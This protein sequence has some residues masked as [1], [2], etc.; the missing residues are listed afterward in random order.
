MQ[1][2]YK[3]HLRD[4]NKMDEFLSRYAIPGL[5][6]NVN[7]DYFKLDLFKDY[8]SAV[9]D[10]IPWVLEDSEALIAGAATYLG[11]ILYSRTHNKCKDLELLDFVLLY[12]N[13][14]Y[15]LDSNKLDESEKRE[16]VKEC[17]K[18]IHNLKHNEQVEIKNYKIQKGYQN[19]CNL[20]KHGCTI[21]TL[22]RCF[23]AEKDSLIESECEEELREICI[24]KSQTCTEIIDEIL[25]IKTNARSLGG[26]VQLFDDMLDY[27]IDKKNNNTTLVGYH[28]KI[29]GILDEVIYLYC[30]LI[31]SLNNY[32]MEF[33]LMYGLIIY[34]SKSP[35]VSEYLKKI[36]IKYY[37]FNNEMDPG[38]Y[39][40][41]VII[42]ILTN[43]DEK[44]FKIK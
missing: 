44:E 8:L 2:V 18:L 41:S 24:I 19:L 43:V 38:E 21:E 7:T 9:K 15:I 1:F 3:F 31:K 22:E 33:F 34:V 14:D 13:I 39:V 42:E 16:V 25:N 6:F 32:V 5:K 12:I 36:F 40:K 30:N 29:Y 35:Y 27:E 4:N 28:I 10:Q 23:M 17:S 37:P 11:A 26:C 20:V